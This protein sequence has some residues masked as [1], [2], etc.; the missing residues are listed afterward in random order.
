MDIREEGLEE[1]REIGDALRLISLI[2]LY[3][4]KSAEEILELSN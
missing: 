2:K 3:P 1:G 4:D